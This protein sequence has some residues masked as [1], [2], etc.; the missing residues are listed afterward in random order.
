MQHIDERRMWE[1]LLDGSAFIPEERD[2]MSLCL[3]CQQRHAMLTLLRDELAVARAST[4]RPNAEA[5][6]FSILAQVGQGSP[7][8]LP[9]HSL[10][11]KMTEWVKAM[12]LWDSRQQAGAIGVRS[13]SHSSYRMLFGVE[14]TEI[15][16][17]VEPQGQFLRLKGEV[18]VADDEVNGLA[19]IELALTADAKR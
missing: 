19:L 7:Q 12:P 1:E 14:K 16:L 4:V 17:M 6:L 15:E 10:V 18:M 5:R 8:E 9:F 11:S 2:H 13:A 3:E